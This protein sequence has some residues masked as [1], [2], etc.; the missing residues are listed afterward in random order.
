VL[1]RKAYSGNLAGTPFLNIPMDDLA[2]VQPVHHM[3]E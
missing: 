2:G 3:R 1:S